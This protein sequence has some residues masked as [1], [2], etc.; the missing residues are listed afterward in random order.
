MTDREKAIVSAYTGYAMLS[1]EMQELSPLEIIEGDFYYDGN[2]YVY[3]AMSNSP[4][5]YIY[6]PMTPRVS[7]EFKIENSK[8]IEYQRQFCGDSGVISF[9]I[10]CDVIISVCISSSNAQTFIINNVS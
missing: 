4:V 10:N 5:L 8:E 9:I 7:K 3:S 6:N 1:L 2:E